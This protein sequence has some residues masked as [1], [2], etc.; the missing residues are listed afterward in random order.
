[1]KF[2]LQLPVQ[3]QSSVFVEPWELQA[4]PEEMLAVAQ[5][6]DRAGFDHVGVC[7]HTAIPSD[8]LD[9]MG[10]TWFE[11]LTTL[12][13]V[14]QATTR[15]R[16]LTHVYV[17]AQ[18]NP[19]HAAKAFATL[20]QLSAGRVVIGVGAGHVA[21]EFA[22]A[23]GSFERRG[24]D[25]DEGIVALRGALVDEVPSHDGV[26]WQHEGLT[27]RPRPVQQPPPIWVG[28]SSTPAL[29]RAGR[30]GDGWIPQGTRLSDMPGQ[31]AQLARHRADAGREGLPF[32]VGGMA[33]PMYLG[34]PT[35]DVGPWTK[36]GSAERLRDLVDRF[37]AIGV[38]HLQIRLR[39][40]SAQELVEQVHGFGDAVIVAADHE[41][42]DTTSVA[43]GTSDV[44]SAARLAN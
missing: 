2:G 3:A 40:S 37:E 39:S 30:L 34:T 4:G 7:D 28:G 22:L 27:V 38:T 1:M 25:L 41:K 6:A 35:W 31:L 43:L 21:E 19:L 23:G 16:L 42:C 8:R 36:S 9:A 14:A 18:R 5:A 12:A 15:V 20:D 29:R 33:L 11:P 26:R 17:L 44:V 10:A 13:W 32:A 24:A